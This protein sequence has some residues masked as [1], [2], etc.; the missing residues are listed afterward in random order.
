MQSNPCSDVH[1]HLLAQY[2]HPSTSGWFP[3][4]MDVYIQLSASLSKHPLSS[5][6]V[7]LQA[8]CTQRARRDLGSRQTAL[9]GEVAGLIGKRTNL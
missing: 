5:S 2:G 8:S 9:D 4:A 3:F 1:V 7:S 6:T